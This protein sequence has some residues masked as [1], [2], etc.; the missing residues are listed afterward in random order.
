MGKPDRAIRANSSVMHSPALGAGLAECL[1]QSPRACDYRPA[2]PRIRD[3]AV[4]SPRLSAAFHN[5]RF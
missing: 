4:T 1:D 5:E 3:Y 2:R